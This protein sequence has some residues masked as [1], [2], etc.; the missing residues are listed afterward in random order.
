MRKWTPGSNGEHLVLT[1]SNHYLT[2]SKDASVN[3]SL[4]PATTIDP[5]NVLSPYLNN[6]V[7]TLDNVVEYWEWTCVRDR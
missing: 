3:S 4:H 7:H 6:A 1:F 2:S 5:F